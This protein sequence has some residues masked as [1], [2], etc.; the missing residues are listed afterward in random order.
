MDKSY[1]PAYNLLRDMVAEHGGSMDYIKE[2]GRAMMA[3]VIKFWINP[4]CFSRA[5]P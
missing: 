5:K 3:W 4:N 2:K 1:R